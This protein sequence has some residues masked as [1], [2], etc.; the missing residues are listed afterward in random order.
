MRD[1]VVVDAFDATL[2][3]PHL[4]R[5]ARRRN[6]LRDAAHG[7][8]GGGPRRRRLGVAG[9][10][11]YA[12]ELDDNNFICADANGNH[13]GLDTLN[14][15]DGAGAPALRR[16]EQRSPFDIVDGVWRRCDVHLTGAW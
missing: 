4:G 5:H 2:E 13:V 14:V 16:G 9:L 11:G 15:C 3:F 6:G 7:R 1:A 10:N 8:D 12:V